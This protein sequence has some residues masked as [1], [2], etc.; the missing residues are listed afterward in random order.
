MLLCFLIGEFSKFTFRVII[1]MRTYYSHFISC[2]LVALY[3]H[4]FFFLV[5]LSAIS[6]WWSSV[7]FF[8]LSSFFM[9]HVSALDFCFVITVTFFGGKMFH[10][11]SSFF[12]SDCICIHLCKLSP[13]PLFMI[14]VTDNPF[15]CCAFISRLQKLQSFKKFFSL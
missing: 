3:F 8:L 4:Y 14:V 10:T 15:L 12:L 11:Y 6:V 5:F 9:F 13:F 2:F 1:D 7:I